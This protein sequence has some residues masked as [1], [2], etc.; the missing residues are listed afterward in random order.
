MCLYSTNR[1]YLV[2]NQLQVTKTAVKPV[3]TVKKLN[4]S[5]NV[6]ILS[7]FQVYSVKL[8]QAEFHTCIW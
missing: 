3:K 7:S 1:V 4:F 5:S 2:L 8:K 6:G